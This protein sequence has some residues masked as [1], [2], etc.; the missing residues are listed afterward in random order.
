[1]DQARYQQKQA[2][3][4]LLIFLF[5]LFFDPEDGGDTFLRYIGLP[6]NYTAFYL[7]RTS[8]PTWL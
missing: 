7:R 1:V 2:A 4:L 5:G 6:R 8:N 3:T